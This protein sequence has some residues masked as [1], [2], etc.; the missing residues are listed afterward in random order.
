M[1]GLP[2]KF[3]NGRE[4]VFRWLALTA[5][6]MIILLVLG[7]WMALRPVGSAGADNV[8]FE[9]KAGDGFRI[10]AAHLADA[11]LIRSRLA[12]EIYAYFTGNARH[13][14]PGIYALSPTISSP[15]ILSSLVSGVAREAEVTVPEGASIFDIDELLANAGVFP[16]GEFVRLA[17]ERKLEGYLFPD[18]YR[19]YLKSSDD[20]IFAKFADNF[21][22]RMTPV[23]PADPGK[24]RD[25]IIIASILEK[26]VPS[27]A[28]RRIVAGILE[29]RL[30][31]GIPLQVDASVCYG[32][33][34]TTGGKPCYPLNRLDTQTESPY[35]TYLHKG[36]PPGPIG[37]PGVS[38][39][40][41]ALSP[42]ASPYL[43]YISDPVTKQTIFAKTL[44][45]QEANQTKYLLQP[46]H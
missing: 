11:R 37:N 40:S 22:K 41:A 31:N 38:A 43:Y 3:D 1:Y 18:T 2:S 16:A 42:L 17:K 23:L 4:N 26:E 25:A 36:L 27:D 45:E 21:I 7:A 34:L 5:G 29:K 30:K 15:G 35:N 9:I 20:E 10:I 8:S 44:E 6:G 19:F 33:R 13:L 14:K 24:S 32:K 12:F 39:V 46:T 28:D